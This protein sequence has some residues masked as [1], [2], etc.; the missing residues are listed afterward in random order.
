MADFQ[1]NPNTVSNVSAN[2]TIQELAPAAVATVY[3]AGNIKTPTRN[4][5]LN[6]KGI[7]LNCI[8]NV[9][10]VCDAALLAAFTATSA[11]VV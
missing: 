7:H 11:P 9:P 10:I 6:Y 1:G 3:G 2:G 4:F 5:T 8:K